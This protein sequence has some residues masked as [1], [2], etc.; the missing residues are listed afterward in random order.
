MSSPEYDRVH[1]AARKLLA[2]ACTRCGATDRLEAALNPETP[3]GRLH[4]DQT[5]NCMYSND[6]LDYV[7]L[8]KACHQH[9]D[10]VEQRTHCK[11]DHEYTPENTSIRPDGSRRCRTCHR[12]QEAARLVDPEARERKRLADR[13]YRKRKPITPEQHDRNMALQ[14]LRRQKGR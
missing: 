10:G 8:C 7:T 9:M 13:E 12:E 11:N 14:R 2:S 1:Y 6:P 4:L 5:I 3:A